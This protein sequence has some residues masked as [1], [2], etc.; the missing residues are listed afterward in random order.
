MAFKIQPDGNS[1]RIGS[2]SNFFEIVLSSGRWQTRY[3]DDG[4]NYVGFQAP[5]LSADQIWTLPEADGVDGD[6]LVTDGA[7]VLSWL[8]GASEKAWTFDSP[9]GCTG[10]FYYGGFYIFHGATFTPA[11][12]TVMGVA[13][14]SYAAHAFVVL[15]ASSTDMVVRVTG[16]SITDGGVRVTSA[17]QDIDTSSGSANDYFETSKK[18]IGQVTFTLLSGTGVIV[19]AGFAKYWDNNNTN[20]KIIGVEAVWLGGAN[21]AGANIIL[22]HHKATGWTYN[23]T[24]TSTPP[25]PVVDM[26]TDHNTEVNIVNDI[27]GAWKRT[28]LSE[29]VAGGNGEGTIVEVITT[30]NRAFELGNFLL[31]IAPQ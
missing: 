18:W 4:G 19:E 3:Y 16:T 20:F 27:D 28:N 21:D 24:G 12:G 17:T 1:Y 26:N 5:P 15:G 9:S 6:V 11:G 14:A 30:A 29:S 2:K 31:R 8:S 22:R 13:N 25:S 23:G 7:G 10:N